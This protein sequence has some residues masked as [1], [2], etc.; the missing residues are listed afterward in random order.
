MVGRPVKVRVMCEIERKF[1]GKLAKRQ[2][3]ELAKKLK[4][5]DDEVE[6]YLC[7]GIAR[8]LEAQIRGEKIELYVH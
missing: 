8:W 7:D 6:L 2:L 3:L 4:D 5:D 1:V